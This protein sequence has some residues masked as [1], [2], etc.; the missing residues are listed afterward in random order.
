MNT[1]IYDHEDI[2]DMVMGLL[3]LLGI[4]NTMA[5]GYSTGMKYSALALRYMHSTNFDCR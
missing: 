4:K 5:A 2:A 1:P 3:S